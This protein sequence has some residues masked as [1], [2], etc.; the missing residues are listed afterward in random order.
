VPDDV[1][2]R[3]RGPEVRGDEVA[4]LIGLLGD[5]VGHLERE[6]RHADPA[7]ERR[8][9]HE[10]DVDAARQLPARR[11]E[12]EA[13]VMPLRRA[14]RD[15]ALERHR[16][17]PLEHEQRADRRRRVAAVQHGCPDDPERAV[18]RD[19]V[20]LD[21]AARQHRLAKRLRSAHD[22]EVHRV[23]QESVNGPGAPDEVVGHVDAR[24][25]AVQPGE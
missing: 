4:L 10:V 9:A 11:A 6:Q 17:L 23:A 14:A 2:G 5:L 18:Q 8:R 15:L 16:L 25:H 24:Q 12:P 13:H 20:R 19:R 3:A 22:A 7:V 1:H 21:P